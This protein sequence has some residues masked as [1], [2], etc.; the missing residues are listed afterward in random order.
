M[1][2]SALHLKII[3]LMFVFA[4]LNDGSRLFWVYEYDDSRKG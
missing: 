3:F 2:F 1:F 4:M